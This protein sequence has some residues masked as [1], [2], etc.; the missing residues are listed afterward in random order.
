MINI[1]NL[2]ASFQNTPVFSNLNFSLP[3]NS[4]TALC[5]INGSGKSTL[6]SLMAGIIPDSLCT[7]GNIFIDGQDILLQ[8][9]GKNTPC[10]KNAGKISFLEQNEKN[11][12]DITV[13]ELVSDGRFIHRKWHQH[14]LPLNK[15]DSFF[16]EQALSFLS[17]QKMQDRRISTLSGGEFQRVRIARSLAQQTKYIF[18]DEPLTA[19]DITFQKELLNIL[20]QLCTQGKTICLSIHD[21]NFASNYADSLL[22]L[23]QDGNGIFSGTPDELLQKHIL[24]QVYG[25]DFSI[26]LHPVTQKKQIW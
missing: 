6:L 13:R 16:I 3:E 26:F 19:L 18:L 8:K 12:W 14:F 4:I 11:F 20:K 24:S 21:L 1:Q 10:T 15:T 5:G 9:H 17:L 7:Q 22:M 2:S 23:R 25:T